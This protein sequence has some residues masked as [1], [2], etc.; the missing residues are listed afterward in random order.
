MQETRAHEEIG[1]PSYNSGV[2]VGPV[3]DQNYFSIKTSNNHLYA[4][5]RLIIYAK[6]G[7]LDD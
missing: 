5:V 4:T 6:S 2:F 1:E 3:L 7:C